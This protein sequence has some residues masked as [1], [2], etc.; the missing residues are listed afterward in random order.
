[1]RCAVDIVDDFIKVC[2]LHR[3]KLETVCMDLNR[4]SARARGRESVSDTE[5]IR[6]QSDFPIASIAQLLH[7]C[8]HGCVLLA[9]LW[10]WK[11]RKK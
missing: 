1:M 7:S 4:E 6:F 5:G 3:L 8:I 2:I 10:T 11:E 9:L